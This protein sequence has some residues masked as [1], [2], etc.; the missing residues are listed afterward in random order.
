MKIWSCESLA[1]RRP[2]LITLT[3]PATKARLKTPPFVAG[4]V[5]VHLACARF[6][7]IAL[8]VLVLVLGGCATGAPTAYRV[9]Y[10]LHEDP[11]RPAPTTMVLLPPDI[12]VS[13]VS[14]GGV[15]EEVPAWTEKATANIKRG[16]TAY[17]ATK[18]NL[19]IFTFPTIAENERAVVDEHL[20]LYDVVA[21]NAYQVTTV[22][23]PAWKHKA[24]HFDYT[25][26]D[27]LA[28]LK[29]R[30]GADAGLLVIGRH[31]IATGGR[32]AASVLAALFGGAYLPTSRNFLTLG[33]V[34]FETGDI[35]WF[36]YTVGASGKD[37]QKVENAGAI[38]KRL[39]EEFPGIGAYKKRR[40][41]KG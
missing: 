21:G 5:T 32:V 22:G 37:M 3:D 38:V 36:N 26:G 1:V 34:D 7:L 40:P 15:V 39:L 17:A 35:L 19:K 41:S 18:A 28:F 9:H 23:G 20:A 8:V 4:E 12:K 27:G 33:V 13:E 14:A 6:D 10:S 16:I 11:V 25:L 30:T 29:K 24:D 2:S 31:Q